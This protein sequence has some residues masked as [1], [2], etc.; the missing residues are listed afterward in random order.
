MPR[1]P[2]L[3]PLQQT[4]EIALKCMNMGMKAMCIL[5]TVWLTC[6]CATAQTEPESTVQ[7]TVCDLVNHPLQFKGKL[8]QVR[9]QIWS[10]YRKFWLNDSWA[11][12]MQIGKVCRWL[13][14]TF[15]HSTN[16]IGCSAFGTFTGRI[17]YESGRAKG[18]LGIRFVVD[19]ESD[20]YNQK[21]Q[22]GVISAPQ[23]YDRSSNTFVGP[24]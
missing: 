8:I 6:V 11:G 13:P 19:H 9:A 5:L 12:S 23:L 7:A 1:R 14:A 22:N 4:R 15:S 17:V 24:G 16:L 20:I 2:R 18:R 21:I 3:S 10:D